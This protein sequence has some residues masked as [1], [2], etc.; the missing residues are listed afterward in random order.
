M[1]S[2]RLLR[3]PA[4]QV[5]LPGWW[6]AILCGVSVG[7]GVATVAAFAT[8]GDRAAPEDGG[9][10]AGFARDMQAHH[11][12]AVQMAFIIRDKTDDETL[13]AITYDIITTQQQ[14][15]GQMFAWLEQWDLPATSEGPSMAWMPDMPDMDHDNGPMPGM[16]TQSEIAR[17]QR[18]DGIWAEKLFLRLMI[19]HHRA[20]IAM[21]RAVQP[22]TDDPQV[23]TLAISITKAQRAE[24]EQ[25]NRLVARY[26]ESG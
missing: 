13:R 14:Q 1:T 5:T 20:G 12:Q 10:E 17:L 25:M 23:T 19:D 15:I 8:W 22:L 4:R 21:A 16:A 9:P 24:I 6:L 26:K 3:A 2:R 7:L 18:L 11:A